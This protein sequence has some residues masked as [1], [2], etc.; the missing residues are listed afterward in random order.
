MVQQRAGLKKV[1]VDITEKERGASQ[2][3]I[4]T[5]GKCGPGGLEEDN[6]NKPFLVL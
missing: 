1:F 6:E 4:D 2:V 5:L 3:S